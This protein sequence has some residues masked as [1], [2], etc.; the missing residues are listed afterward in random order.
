MTDSPVKVPYESR[1]TKNYY[2][3][4]GDT[5]VIGGKLKVLPGAEVEGLGGGDVAPATTT[6]AGIVKMA[7]NQ[8]DSTSTNLLGLATDFNHLLAKLKEAGI[9]APD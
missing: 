4:G 5:L 7:A 6:T 9:M 2:E 1:M 3:D 8:A